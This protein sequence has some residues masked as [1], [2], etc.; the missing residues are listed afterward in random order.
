MKKW[1]R[2]LALD[3]VCLG[4]VA[5]SL[6]LWAVGIRRI[7]IAIMAGGLGV[8]LPVMRREYMAKLT[9]RASA[10]NSPSWSVKLNGVPAGE[11]NDSEYALI[12]L[13]VLRDGK[14][15]FYQ[16]VNIGSALMRSMTTL[17][18]HLPV[19]LVGGG[20]C[21]VLFSPESANEISQAISQ[22]GIFKLSEALRQWLPLLFGY[23]LFICVIGVLIPGFRFGFKNRFKEAIWWDIRIHCGIAAEGE[24]KL[25]RWENDRL[26]VND[27]SEQMRLA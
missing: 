6:V 25:I 18:F 26:V 27:E 7:E 23:F 1:K 21:L 2:F 9:A 8:L 4:L 13:Q 15:Y 14:V 24:I 19:M 10:N 3:V 20:L 22:A 16:F 5:F 12:I 17:L 11:I